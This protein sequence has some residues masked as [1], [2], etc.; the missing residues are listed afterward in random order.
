MLAANGGLTVGG[1]EDMIKLNENNPD[2]AYCDQCSRILPFWVFD[3]TD[4]NSIEKY[5]RKYILCVTAN[6]V[7]NSYLCTGCLNY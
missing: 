1:R 3:G 4:P 2:F 6:S 7:A 5:R